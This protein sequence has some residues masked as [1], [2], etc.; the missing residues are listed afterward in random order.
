MEEE[1][2]VQNN[3]ELND[4][5]MEEAAGGWDSRKSL[6]TIRCRKCGKSYTFAAGASAGTFTCACGCELRG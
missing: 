4:V 3:A 5:Q 2:N 6:K 1:K